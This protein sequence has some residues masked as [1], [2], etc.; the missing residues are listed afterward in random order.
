M[1]RAVPNSPECIRALRH[2]L[3]PRDEA[4]AYPSAVHFMPADLIGEDV[5]EDDLDP[6]VHGQQSVEAD[7]AENRAEFARLFAHACSVPEAFGD[8][9]FLF[10]CDE[11]DMACIIPPARRHGKHVAVLTNDL[12]GLTS[13]A[14]SNG[15]GTS[16][17]FIVVHALHIVCVNIDWTG[18]ARF[19]AEGVG[20]HVEEVHLHR[21][22]GMRSFYRVSRDADHLL[23]TH[24][25]DD[26][27]LH[28]Y[29]DTPPRTYDDITFY[30]TLAETCDVF[31][32]TCPLGRDEYSLALL[33]GLGGGRNGPVELAVYDVDAFA[34]LAKPPFSVAFRNFCQ[35]ASRLRRVR[36]CGNCLC[37]P[38][39]ASL[40]WRILTYGVGAVVFCPRASAPPQ[41][42]CATL[43]YAMCIWRARSQPQPQPRLGRPYV[44]CANAA[45]EK[46]VPW[47]ERCEDVHAPRAVYDFVSAV[48]PFSRD[49]ETETDTETVVAAEDES[50]GA[51]AASILNAACHMAKTQLNALVGRHAFLDAWHLEAWTDAASAPRRRAA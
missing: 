30:G 40:A 1:L 22:S 3:R 37:D 49:T 29:V 20:R 12:S 16:L 18:F 10:S 50:S 26:T 14:R 25:R 27:S 42:A 6:S 36:F 5:F 51:A 2:V 7:D 48:L 41:V 38:T 8:G 11:R 31:R 32:Y 46:E 35:R 15:V 9:V 23:R 44:S 21:A 13:L 43:A 45:L 4:A 34:L 33:H 28:V 47:V 19:F 39:C 17:P 24:L